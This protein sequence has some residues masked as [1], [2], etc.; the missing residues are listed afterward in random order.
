MSGVLSHAKVRDANSMLPSPPPG[1][2]VEGTGLINWS[3]GTGLSC[4]DCYEPVAFPLQTTTYVVT[5]FDEHGCF[6]T[7]NLTRYAI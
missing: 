4:A 5:E 7:D 1:V 3:P 6:A 2:L